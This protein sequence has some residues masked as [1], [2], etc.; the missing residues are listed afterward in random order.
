[1]N[2]DNNDTPSQ[3]GGLIV[4]HKVPDRL[5][6][7][8]F[9]ACVL[10]LL[11]SSFLPIVG[12][13]FEWV[14]IHW[15]TGLVLTAALV[16]HIYRTWLRGKWMIMWFG[17]QDIGLTLSYLKKH[18]GSPPKPGKYSPAQKLMHLG[19]TVLVGLTIIT[20]LI[21][22]VKIDTPFWERNI[23][24]LEDGSWGL[25][26]ALHGIAALGLITT[27]MLHIYFSL[28]PE[29]LMYTRSMIK[30]W[31]TRAEF[32]EHHDPEKWQADSND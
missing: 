3:A 7:W 24:L 10:V 20:G 29:K 9:A 11:F 14:T 22:M 31:L 12:L 4:R 17:L 1:M 18:T 27:I 28:R 23:Y 13:K 5:L 2:P 15:V 19:V 30:G 26:Y 16:G 21:M 6:H 8:T 25:I 32:V